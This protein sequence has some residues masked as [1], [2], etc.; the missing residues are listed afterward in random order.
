MKGL[1]VL[2]LGMFLWCNASSTQAQGNEFT[3]YFTENFAGATNRE[4][5][6][7]SLD[8]RG[9]FISKTPHQYGACYLYLDA[10]ADAGITVYEIVTTLEEGLG[11]ALT[12]T[13]TVLDLSGISID[14]IRVSADKGSYGVFLPASNRYSVKSVFESDVTESSDF[15]S[16]RTDT[17][18]EGEE[19]KSRIFEAASASSGGDDYYGDM[20]GITPLS[21]DPKYDATQFFFFTGK[22][23]RRSGE[24]LE[25][26]GGYCGGGAVIGT[27]YQQYFY[28]SKTRI[29]VLTT[30]DGEIVRATELQLSNYPTTSSVSIVE[31]N[32]ETQ[33][34]IEIP[35]V[36]VTYDAFSSQEPSSLETYTYQLPVDSPE[37]AMSLIQILCSAN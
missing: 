24:T 30:Q 33:L 32:G 7:T 8:L 35:L 9:D 22:G 17:K 23:S 19:F 28:A 4:Y 25:V 5:L 20:G 26:R 11:E 16:F 27:K 14:D 3:I 34:Y 2:S 1:S 13:E 29:Y 36:E 37:T 18:A 21:D 15:A 6:G 31:M 12:V 10:A